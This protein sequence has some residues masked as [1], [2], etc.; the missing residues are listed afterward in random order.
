MRGKTFS[1]VN[2][3]FIFYSDAQKQTVPLFRY[4]NREELKVSYVFKTIDANEN[5]VKVDWNNVVENLYAKMRSFK[6]GERIVGILKY[7]VNGKYLNNN[8]L[9]CIIFLINTLGIAYKN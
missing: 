5:M 3:F 1:I 8:I 4:S 7:W 9:Y 2:F 6:D